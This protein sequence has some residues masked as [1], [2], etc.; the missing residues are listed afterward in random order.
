MHGEPVA[1]KVGRLAGEVVNVGPEHDDVAR[2]AA[3]L[4]I[5]T[6]TAWAQAWAAARQ[7]LE[8]AG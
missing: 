6:K 7:E 2:A 1:V 4:G 8:S 3:A 5:P